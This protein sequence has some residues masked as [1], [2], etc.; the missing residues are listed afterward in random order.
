MNYSGYTDQ[1]LVDW[2]RANGCKCAQPTWSREA[3]ERNAE[4][5]DMPESVM[6][7]ATEP[8]EFTT[9]TIGTSELAET[10]SGAVVIASRNEPLLTWTIKNVRK[11]GWQGEIVVVHDGWEEFEDAGCGERHIT[12]GPKPIGCP[13]SRHTGIEYAEKL[14]CDVAIVIDAHMSFASGALD[15]VMAHV[16]D[17][18]TDVAGCWSGVL[19]HDRLS[20]PVSISRHA[21]KIDL[22]NT[23]GNVICC[24]W[25]RHVER[26]PTEPEEVQSLLGACYGFTIQRYR[27]IG[28]P[29]DGAYG[30]GASE[31]ALCL[32]NA[33]MGGRAMNLPTIANHVY[34]DLAGAKVPYMQESEMHRAGKVFNRIRI[35]QMLP[36]PEDKK[37]EL[38]EQIRRSPDGKKHYRRAREIW[39]KAP[40]KEAGVQWSVSW[41]DYCEKWWP[42]PLQPAKVEPKPEEPKPVRRRRTVQRRAKN[43]QFQSGESPS[44]C[45][46]CGSPEA[47]V[48]PG[49]HYIGGKHKR[50][51]KCLKC[52][53]RFY[54]LRKVS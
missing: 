50:Y 12:S 54:T 25:V 1:E 39:Q 3:L 20:A 44:A 45:P 35:V 23:T 47:R 52:K 10:H 43:F 7:A 48:L 29:W 28:Q 9:N 27:D 51:R 21:A 17:N 13:I 15:D 8:Y 26:V 46:K 34:R 49:S 31:Q 14:G 22:V 38:M 33:F 37:I 32:F 42:E 2:L 4:K 16:I 41:E 18:P 24:N 6:V 5:L 36:I 19:Q 53:K 30:W 40:R 11:C